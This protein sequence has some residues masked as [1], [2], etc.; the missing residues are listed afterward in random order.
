MTTL[1]LIAAAYTLGAWSERSVAKPA[2]WLS[3]W[4]DRAARLARRMLDK[5]RKG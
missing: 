4:N 2:M 3:R 5:V 1:I